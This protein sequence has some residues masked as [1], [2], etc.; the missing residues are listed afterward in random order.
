MST[1]HRLDGP[2]FQTFNSDGQLSNEE[3]YINDTNYTKYDYDAEIFKMKL[4][5]L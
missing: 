1:F 3:Y 4:T 5:L 2:S